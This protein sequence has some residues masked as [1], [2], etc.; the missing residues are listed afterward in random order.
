MNTLALILA[1]GGSKRIPGKNIRQLGEMPL[2]AWS[3]AAA[4]HARSIDVVVVS[5]DS[6]V[7]L[8]IARKH[9]AATIKRPAIMATDAASSYPAMLHA[10][11]E[12]E[13]S[14]DWVC[15]LQPTSPFRTPQD[16]DDC[17]AA[18]IASGGPAAV[19]VEL[20]KAVPNGA[21]YWANV[22]WLLETIAAGNEAP[23]DGP[24]PVH[25]FMPAKRSI[26]IDTEDDWTRA[27]GM[28]TR[29]A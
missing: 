20:G 10:I 26:D 14:F 4:F 15:L 3:I 11:N 13:G 22:G 27:E 2:I 24:V 1:R 9:G 25:Y 12:L 19:S 29:A 7:I 16:V 18:A 6:D 23:F 21:V 17:F 28:L 5:S 8:D